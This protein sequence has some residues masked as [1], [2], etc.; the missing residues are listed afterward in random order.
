[1]RVRPS[2]LL[3]SLLVTAAFVAACNRSGGAASGDGGVESDAAAS[4]TV[5]ATQGQSSVPQEQPT[6]K[7]MLGI[8]AFVTTGYAEPRDTSK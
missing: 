7:P 6:D 5:P 3:T 1:M 2:F 4:D 8:T